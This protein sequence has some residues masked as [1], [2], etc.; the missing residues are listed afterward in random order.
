MSK[1]TYSAVHARQS[2]R[3]E[4]VSFAAKAA[5]VLRFAHIDRVSRDGEGRLSGFQR[6][7]IAAHIREIQDYLEKP[8]AVLPNPIVVAFTRGIEVKA[9]KNGICQLT[10][11]I[12][13]GPS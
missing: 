11:D 1:L 8:E 6:P 10:I 4:V 5:D 3:H 2:D 12:S 7:Q 13:D 9:G